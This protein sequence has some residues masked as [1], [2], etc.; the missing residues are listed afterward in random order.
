MKS[1]QCATK[2]SIYRRHGSERHHN[3][4]KCNETVSVTQFC[5]QVF[6]SHSFATKLFFRRMVLRWKQIFIIDLLKKKAPRTFFLHFVSV[7]IVFFLRAGRVLLSK[8]TESRWNWHRRSPE[9]DVSWYRH[10]S[11]F[12]FCVSYDLRY[13]FPSF[14][15]IIVSMF[16]ISE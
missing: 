13:L 8:I 6:S 2:N 15:P 11:L 9:S 7:S 14:L 16:S 12:P 3:Y 4:N 10:L 1:Q 5:K